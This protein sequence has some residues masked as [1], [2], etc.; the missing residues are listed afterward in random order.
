MKK[1]SFFE[2]MLDIRS[3]YTGE[4]R[5]IHEVRYRDAANWCRE[6]ETVDPLAYFT[7]ITERR[8][9][10]QRRVRDIH[11]DGHISEWWETQE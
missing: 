3:A 10:L 5:T 7:P 9:R 2:E 6:A 11:P 8:T 4:E 1:K